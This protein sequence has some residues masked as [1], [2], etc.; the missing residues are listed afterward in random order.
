L[1]QRTGPL[2]TPIVCHSAY[3]SLNVL[4]LAFAPNSWIVTG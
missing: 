4:I 2:L 3:N 1:R